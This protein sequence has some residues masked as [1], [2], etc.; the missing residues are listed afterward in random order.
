MTLDGFVGGEDERAEA[1]RLARA[2]AGGARVV[3]ALEVR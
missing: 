2:A 3:D 1:L